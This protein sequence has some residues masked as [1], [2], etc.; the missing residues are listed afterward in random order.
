MEALLD[1]DPAIMQ[2]L[3]EA[4]KAA[5]EESG[6]PLTDYYDYHHLHMA[7]LSK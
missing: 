7:D 1:T 6:L 3:D 4:G 2:A 5:E